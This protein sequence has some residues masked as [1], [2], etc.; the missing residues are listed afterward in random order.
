M[1]RIAVQSLA[2]SQF[3]ILG[4][5]SFRGPLNRVPFSEKYPIFCKYVNV[6]VILENHVYGYLVFVKDAININ[7]HYI[8]LL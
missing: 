4:R 1:I 6:A 2:G 7:G 3:G 8:N 5:V